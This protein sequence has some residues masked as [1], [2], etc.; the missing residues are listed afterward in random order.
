[1][2]NTNSS[3]QLQPQYSSSGDTFNYIG[4]LGTQVFNPHM[5]RSRG[6]R[7]GYFR[8]KLICQVFGKGGHSALQCYHRFDHGFNGFI[9]IGPFAFMIPQIPQPSSHIHHT[10]DSAQALVATR[11]I[12][13]HNHFPTNIAITG[14]YGSVLLGISNHKILTIIEILFSI[15][16]SYNQ[17]TQLLEMIILLLLWFKK[18]INLHFQQAL[19]I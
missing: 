19:T 5:M 9:V 3:H 12:P 14:S 13:N 17:F 18:G 4:S 10:L 8:P 2:R 1:M 11:M 7:R 15:I 16:L 6:R